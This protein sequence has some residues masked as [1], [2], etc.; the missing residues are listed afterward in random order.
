M[1][2]RD[3][4]QTIGERIRAA[5]QHF[6][7]EAGSVELLAVSKKHPAASI[8]EAIATGQT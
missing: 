7:R 4:I 6:G 2:I 5:E 8:R 3:N 1:T